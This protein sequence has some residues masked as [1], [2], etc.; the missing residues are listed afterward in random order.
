MTRVSRIVDVSFCIPRFWRLLF[1]F[2]MQ[3]ISRGQARDR[4]RVAFHDKGK[5]RVVQV[6]FQAA[7][8][9]DQGDRERRRG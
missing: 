8:S 3:L 9:S 6:P 2:G 5:T 7:R 4:H 1:R